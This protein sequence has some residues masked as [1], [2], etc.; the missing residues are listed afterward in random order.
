MNSTASSGQQLSVHSGG[1]RWGQQE[2]DSHRHTKKTKLTASH[3]SLN[4]TTSS[5]QRSVH[6]NSKKLSEDVEKSANGSEQRQ[7]MQNLLAPTERGAKAPMKSGTSAVPNATVATF[8]SAS[9][10]TLNIRR[11]GNEVEH[12]LRRTEHQDSQLLSG[13]T[14]SSISVEECDSSSFDEL[15]DLDR[16]TPVD[17]RQPFPQTPIG[18]PLTGTLARSGAIHKGDGVKDQPVIREHGEEQLGDELHL[19]EGLK[20]VPLPS[21]L[22]W[23]GMLYP[24]S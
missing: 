19:K 5:G 11:F 22:D 24:Q 14:P 13:Q 17:L 9:A 1:E 23:Q 8:A 12:P 7:L 4:S 18:V 20:K 21:L 6:S 10:G 16:T 15:N 2:T 3:E